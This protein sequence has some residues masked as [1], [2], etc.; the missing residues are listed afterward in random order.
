MKII[1]IILKALI[2]IAFMLIPFALVLAC[3]LTVTEE[4]TSDSVVLSAILFFINPFYITLVS[5]YFI[6]KKSVAFMYLGAVLPWFLLCLP[7]LMRTNDD[8]LMIVELELHAGLYQIIGITVCFAIACLVKYIIYRNKASED[9][10]IYVKKHISEEI[11]QIIK[12][13]AL[14]FA[15]PIVVYFAIFLIDLAIHIPGISLKLI[16]IWI[17]AEPIYMALVSYRFISKR[18]AVYMYFGLLIMQFIWFVINA[19]DRESEMFLGFIAI[20]IYKV[21]AVT[22]SF[23]I[24]CLVKYIVY[25]HKTKKALGNDLI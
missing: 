17:V 4:N 5:Y 25:R 6:N 9:T 22:I 13:A 19:V 11:M 1:N 14:C 12:W 18:K 7:Y 23:A 16:Y 20:V 2:W 21:I 24:A 8:W 15:L 10:K 3:L